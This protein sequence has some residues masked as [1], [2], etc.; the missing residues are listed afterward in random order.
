[1]TIPNHLHDD[2]LDDFGSVGSTMTNAV[3]SGTLSQS[4]VAYATNSSNKVL[5]DV[6][7][8]TISIDT[9]APS[10]APSALP[11]TAPSPEPSRLPSSL[12]SSLPSPAP[13]CAVVDDK[14]RE[15]DGFFLAVVTGVAGLLVGFCCACCANGANRVVGRLTK[16][17][18]QKGAY[19]SS[20]VACDGEH[21]GVWKASG[22]AVYSVKPMRDAFTQTVIDARDA[23]TQTAID[24]DISRV[25]AT[26][27][28]LWA[29]ASTLEE[30]LDDDGSEGS[31]VATIVTEPGSVR[32]VKVLSRSLIL[33][34]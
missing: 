18:H 6:C 13:T 22:G 14:A 4:I 15:D 31:L 32:Y 34:A 29:D 20:R 26:S 21:E 16:G 9:L 30:Q 8:K 10:P 12:P 27:D 11:S 5:A 2:A 24:T 28:T 1:V 25:V 3:T 23:L 7:V 33:V 19:A 17:A